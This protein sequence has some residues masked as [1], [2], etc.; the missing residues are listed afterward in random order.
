MTNMKLLQMGEV[1]LSLFLGHIGWASETSVLSSL[2]TKGL[3]TVHSLKTC[4]SIGGN[5]VI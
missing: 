2:I 1:G 4:S 3:G 5:H